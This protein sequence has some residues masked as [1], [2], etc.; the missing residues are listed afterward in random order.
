LVAEVGDDLARLQRWSF[1][2]SRIFVM[3]LCKA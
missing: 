2:R 3:I 1:D